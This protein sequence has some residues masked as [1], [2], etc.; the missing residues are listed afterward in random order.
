MEKGR[1]SLSDEL[2]EQVAGGAVTETAGDF[3]ALQKMGLLPG[4]EFLASSVVATFD[5]FGVTCE[6]YNDLN[7]ANRYFIGDTEV[8]RQ[9]ALA[10][11]QARLNK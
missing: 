7:T 11:V 10:H 1:I 5:K 6:A 8:T 9:Q 4:E 2:L 3:S